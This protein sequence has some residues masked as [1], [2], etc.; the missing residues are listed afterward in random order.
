MT[1]PLIILH[2]FTYVEIFT[3]FV[4]VYVYKKDVNVY[5]TIDDEEPT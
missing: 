4:Y 2:P 3:S 5:I 1:T